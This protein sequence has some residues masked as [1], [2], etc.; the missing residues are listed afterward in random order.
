MRRQRRGSVIRLTAA[1][2]AIALTGACAHNDVLVFGTSTTIGLNVETASTNGAAP[3]IVLG[4][5][6][7]EAVWMPLLANGRHSRISPCVSSDR[8]VCT[9]GGYPLDDAMY[10]STIMDPSGQRVV[11]TDTYSVFASLGAHFNGKASTNNGAE[12]GGG[13]AQFFAT[14]NAAVNISAN[15]ALV[16]ALKVSS[17]ASSAAQANAVAAASGNST[18][19]STFAGLTPAQIAAATD[20]AQRERYQQLRKADLVLSCATTADGTFRWADIVGRLSTTD[21]PDEAQSNL[22]TITTRDALRL[23]LESNQFLTAD[24]LAVATAAPF[25]CPGA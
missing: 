25:N 23:R 19:V 18:E 4:Y 6:R 21:Y 13:L 22:R 3:S 20:T 11:Q 1:L 17:P 24:A 12:A 16:T 2:G 14:G 15:E 8:N 10:R 5:E 9:P 7:E